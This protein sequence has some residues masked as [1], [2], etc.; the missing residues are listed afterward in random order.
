[1][2]DWVMSLAE[3]LSPPDFDLFMMLCWVIWG[4]RNS[5]LWNDKS[6]N[7]DNFRWKR[8][9]RGQL[10]LNVDGAWNKELNTGVLVL[11]FVTARGTLLLLL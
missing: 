1:M 10:K 11:L 2:G 6:S 4:A 8:P 7:P 3:Q 9:P 5:R